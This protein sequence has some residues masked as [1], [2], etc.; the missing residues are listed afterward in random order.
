L[1]NSAAE[2][3][4]LRRSYE[5]L[6]ARARRNAG[7]L[8]TFAQAHGWVQALPERVEWQTAHYGGVI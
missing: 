3:N 8:R 2:R 4:I 5:D 1:A 7:I 6:L